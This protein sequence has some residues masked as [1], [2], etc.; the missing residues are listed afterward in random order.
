[1]DLHLKLDTRD[2]D[3]WGIKSDHP[4]T[5]VAL[6]TLDLNCMFPAFRL[7]SS[8]VM[9]CITEIEAAYHEENAYH[10]SRHAADV[11]QA[12]HYFIS[13]CHIQLTQVEVFALL[14]AGMIHDVRCCFFFI[15]FFFLRWKLIY[16]PFRLAI[17]ARTIHSKLQQ[18]QS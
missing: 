18:S 2:F 1:M 8:D 14:L 5:H 17:L 13:N 11:V 15:F 6:I 12:L 9:A 10:N 7:E 16:I 4:L 3:P